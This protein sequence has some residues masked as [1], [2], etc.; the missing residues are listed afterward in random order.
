MDSK[1]QFTVF[2]ICVGIGFIGGIVYEIFAFIRFL[3]G[4]DRGKNKILGGVLDCLFFVA[5]AVVCIY[6]AFAFRFPSFRVYIWI[7]YAVGGI[8][9]AKSFRRIVAF[10]EKVCYNKL[11]KVQKRRKDKKKLSQNGGA[12]I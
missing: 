12:E 1:N 9:Y 4:C 3:F 5:F 10:L 11:I 8:F 6:A 7:G 2:C